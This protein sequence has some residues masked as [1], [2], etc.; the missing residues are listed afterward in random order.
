VSTEEP[1]GFRGFGLKVQVAFAG[2]LETTNK[3][4]VLTKPFTEVRVIV[5]FWELPC[6]TE[7]ELGLAEIE[8]SGFTAGFTTNVAVAE[9][10]AL[11]PV[12]VKVR[13]A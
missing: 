5:D 13:F 2:Q 1:V 8:K 7:R 3:F 6:D 4:T 12:P 11:G 10:D 9:C